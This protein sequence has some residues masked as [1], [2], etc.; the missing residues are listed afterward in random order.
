[1][2]SSPPCRTSTPC[3]ARRCVCEYP[4]YLAPQPMAPLTSDTPLAMPLQV[5][6]F[7]SKQILHPVYYDRR[8]HK[9]TSVGA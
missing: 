2:T 5:S 6:P 4:P 8:L 3:A 7:E 9:L 1:M